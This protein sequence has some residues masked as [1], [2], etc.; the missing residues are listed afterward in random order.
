MNTTKLP[1]PIA[2]RSAFTLIELL[3][4]IAII[5][6]LAGMLLPVIASVKK[7]AM[8][9]RATAEIA[10]IV[11]AIKGYEN[12][13]SRMPV[14]SQTALTAGTGDITF[15][16]NPSSAEVIAILMDREITVNG[17]QVNKDHVKNTKQFKYLGAKEVSDVAQGGV[18]P[19]LVYRDPWGNPY[20]ISL[21]MNLDDK[22][23]DNF[24]SQQAVSQSGGAT[25]FDGL[26]NTT[27]AGGNGNNFQYNGNFM[28]WSYGPDKTIAVG[29]KSNEGV[30]KDNIGN[31]K[32]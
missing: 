5:A 23:L 18:G 24:Y 1:Y 32:Q 22:C 20:I 10:S 25:G 14:T 30:N 8:V 17:V 12:D 13:Y 31:W 21:D 29:V 9:K 3:V 19:D 28:V 2:R 15:D 4:V 27:D 16:G 11:L 6:I 26:L 7:K